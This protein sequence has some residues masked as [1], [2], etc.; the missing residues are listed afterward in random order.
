MKSGLPVDSDFSADRFFARA[1]ERLAPTPPEAVGDIL[2]DHVLNPDLGANEAAYRDAA[3]L[4]P[5]VAR[6]PSVSVLLTVRTAH[7]TAHAGQIAFP[8]GKIDPTDATPAAAAIREAEEEVGLKPSGIQTVGYLPPYLSRTGYR[9]FPV[10]GRVD[11]DQSLIINPEEVVEAFEVP[12]EFLMTPGNHRMGHRLFE[13]KQ[14]A[15]YEM[16]YEGHYIWGVTAGIIR[17]LYERMFD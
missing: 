15:F 16:P 6:A 10:V 2:G 12:L 13:G 17:G 11:P 1:G 7:L 5:V 8:G 3:V 4:I 14:R 9:I